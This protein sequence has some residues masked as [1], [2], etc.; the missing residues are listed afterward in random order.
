VETKTY[1]V[2][3]VEGEEATLKFPRAGPSDMW[4]TGYKIIALFNIF[5]FLLPTM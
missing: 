1:H 2:N 5:G 4:V 3:A